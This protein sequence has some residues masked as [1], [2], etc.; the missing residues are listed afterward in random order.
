MPKLYFKISVFRVEV[1]RGPLVAKTVFKISVF[2]VGIYWIPVGAQLYFQISGF[3]TEI[4]SRVL[5]SFPNWF[6]NLSI[7]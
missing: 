5:S 2:R 7:L 4:L 3:S 6:K 1:Y